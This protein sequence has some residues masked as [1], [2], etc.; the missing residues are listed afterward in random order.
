[1]KPTWQT[2]LSIEKPVTSVRYQSET[3]PLI[4]IA[5]DSRVVRVSLKNILQ[6]DY[7]II[8][9]EDGSQAWE[10]LHKEPGI[11]LVFSDLSMPKLDGLGLLDNIRHSDDERIRMI[12][13]IVVTG[14][15]EDEKIRNQLLQQGANDLITKPFVNH[16]ITERAK[17]HIKLP[18]EKT[19]SGIEEDEFLT[20]ITNKAR[21]T[22]IVRKELS[23]AIRNKNELALLLLKLDQFETIKKHYSD[24][25]IEH[26]LITTAEIIRAHTHIDDKIAYFGE[27]T[28]A[29]LLPA[30]NAIGTRYL[31]KR[32]LSD[33]VAKKFY[34]GE[35]DATVT[36]SIGVSAPDIKPS[37]TFSEILHLAEQRLQAAINAGGQRVVDKGNATITPV[38][39]LLTND[40]DE[41]SA[42]QRLLKQ[43]E[44]EMRQLASQEVEKIKANRQYENEIDSSLTNAHEVNDALLLAEHENKLIKEELVRSR[45]QLEEMEQLKKKLHETDS[46]LQQTHHKFKQL[47]T[48]YDEMKRRADDAETRQAEWMVPDIDNSIVEQH[49]LQENDQLQQELNSANQR[50]EEIHSAFRKSELIISNLKQQLKLHKDESDLALAESNMKRSIA[51]QRIAELESR[52]ANFKQDKSQLSLTSAPLITPLVKNPQSATSKVYNQAPA[53]PIHPQPAKCHPNKAERSKPLE[54]GRKS[55]HKWLLKV[56]AIG[57]FIAIGVTVYLF[58]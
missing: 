57:I 37:T 16:E 14:N 21:F 17:R 32:I 41:Q 7:H 50:I 27:G 33:L 2:T 54:K 29:I 28:F 53:Q 40:G 38:S 49:L 36:A 30:S 26:I 51:E 47:R 25:A 13:F 44:K 34:L 12:P 23:F 24:P 3:K 31:G 48:E 5:D 35:S 52:I 20:G 1:M 18:L 56:A 19:G 58:W 9:A 4:L 43:T 46:R 15:D 55:N 8:E 11:K 10:V 42:Q 6:Q 22:Q 39:T 45:L